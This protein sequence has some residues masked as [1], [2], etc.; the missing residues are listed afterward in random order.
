MAARIGATRN[1]DTES[2][3]MRFPRSCLPSLAVLAALAA[4]PETRAADVRFEVTPFLGYRL[5]GGFDAEGPD[6]TSTGSVDVDDGSSWGIDVGLYARPDGFYELLYSTQSTGLDSREPALAGVDVTTEYYQIGGTA[7]FPGEQWLVPYVSMTVGATRFSADGFDS[8]TKFSG[9]LGGGL[10]LP[11]TDH[12]AATI[13]VRGYL[14]FI[15]SDTAF[16]CAS[17]AE[18][19]GCLVTSS[20]STFFQAEAQLGLTAR[21]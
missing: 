19:A 8:E 10:R 20:G 7:F 16:L 12:F 1:R 3:P 11:F 13:G 6:G 14:T 2:K 18:Q 4:A 15:E 5:G 17:N 9:S 21:F